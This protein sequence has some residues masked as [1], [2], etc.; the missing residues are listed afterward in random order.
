[1]RH[2]SL[3]V[4]LISAGL[5]TTIGI[6]Q[7]PPPPSELSPTRWGVVYD[8]PATSR[9][10][11]Q[12]DIPF[13][14]RAT[15]A[16]TLDLYQPPD[17]KRGEKRPA[18]IFLNAIGDRPGDKIKRWAIYRTWPRLVAAHGMIGISMDADPDGMQESIRGLFRFLEVDGASL[19]IDA[20]RLGMYAASANVNGAATYLASDSASRGIRAVALFYGRPPEEDLRTDL[21]TLFIVA[22]GDAPGMAPALAAL[23][24]RVVESGAPWTLQFAAG[25]PHAFDALS[26]SDAARR[27]IQQAIGFWKSNL[28]IVPAPPW[29]PSPARAIVASLFAHD[30][31]RSAALLQDWVGSHPRDA[32]ALTSLGRALAELRR[33]PESEAAYTRAYALDSSNPGVLVG[34][35]QARLNQHRWEEAVDLLGRARRAG[36]ENSLL[37][38]QMGWAQLNLNRNAEAAANYEQAIELGIPPGPSTLGL[39]WYN[40]ACAYVRLGRIDHAIA[41]LGKAIDGGMRDRA[42]LEQDADLHP[43]RT[44]PRFPG[45]LARLE[46]GAR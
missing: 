9:V 27:V 25:M 12:E 17:L 3:V 8:I 41:A 6:A 36:I 31:E 24:Q 16:L 11:V 21:P 14:R 34:L 35:G 44:D 4:M 42:S 20:D 39:A 29:R 26:D 5:R 37:V 13:L 7:S 22:A 43:L 45:L 30:S 10:T 2:A 33:F 40:L 32:E 28:E 1:M 38:G 18:V 15:G 19:G 46:P 23:W